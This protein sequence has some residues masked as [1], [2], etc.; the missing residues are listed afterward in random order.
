VCESVC[1]CVCVC[2]CVSVCACARLFTYLGNC[3]RGL[4]LSPQTAQLY[5]AD[6]STP[7]NRARTIAPVYAAF[8]IG[9]ACGPAIGGILGSTYGLHAP[10]LLVGASMLSAGALNYFTISETLPRARQAAS[11]P[12]SRSSEQAPTPTLNATASNTDVGVNNPPS[13][14]GLASAAHGEESKP[15]APK[16]G[17]VRQTVAQWMAI[18]ASPGVRAVLLLNTVFWMVNTGTQMGIV[19]F[20]L[21]DKY[22]FNLSNLGAIFA[23][24]SI[25]SVAASQPAAWVADRF[26]RK[27]AIIPGVATVCVCLATLP[28]VTEPASAVALLAAWSLGGALLGTSP[29]AYVVDTTSAENRAQAVALLRS[30]GDLG[31]LLGGALMGALVEHVSLFGATAFGASILGAAV[32]NFARSAV[33]APVPQS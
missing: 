24:T 6:I 2:V 8:G 33:A 19:P 28:A 26:G 11:S 12:A 4:S 16:L 22:N 10:F 32:V 17:A 18:A 5:L 31:L 15:A 21:S 30:S 14:T 9:T 23:M 29:L 13:S 1:V 27:A 25:I 7:A 20:L 3:H